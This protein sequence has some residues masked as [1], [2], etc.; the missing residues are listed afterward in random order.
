MLYSVNGKFL[1][2][3]IKH[4]HTQYLWASFEKLELGTVRVENFEGGKFRAI[5]DCVLFR[6]FRGF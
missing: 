5:Q 3:K 6:T 4:T 1:R 2:L